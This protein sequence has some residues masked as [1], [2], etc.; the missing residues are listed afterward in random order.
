MQWLYGVGTASVTQNTTAVVGSTGAFE[1]VLPFHEISFAEGAETTDPEIVGNDRYQVVA[2]TDNENITIYP[3]FKPATIAS[4]PF[5][6]YRFSI[7]DQTPAHLA[8]QFAKLHNDLQGMV[9]FSG[10]DRRL[11]LS[12]AAS[13]DEAEVI[14]QSAA[15]DVYRHGLLETNEWRLQRWNSGW[16]T[17]IGTVSG[18][19]GIGTVAAT[20][21][22]DV[23]ASAAA[24]AVFDTQ[25][26][27]ANRGGSI[28][29][30]GF[31][32]HATPERTTWAS[33]QGLGSDG[34][35]GSEDGDMVGKTMRAGTLTEA[36]RAKNTG[37]F[38]AGG[39]EPT[40]T[41][42]PA[43][44][45]YLPGSNTVGLSSASLL[46]VRM[47]AASTVGRASAFTWEYKLQPGA[48]ARHGISFIGYDVT[49]IFSALDFADSAGVASGAINVDQA[50]H[51]TA[52]TTS[53]D[54]R[55]KPNRERL[56]VERA[57]D[58]V[59]AL[60]IWDFDKDG[61]YIRGVGPI[62][63]EAYEVLPRMVQKGDDNESLRP[64]D[65]DYRGWSA[66]KSY[67]VPYLIVAVQHLLE[68][69]EA[70]NPSLGVK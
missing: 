3:A 35:Q 1:D 51:T 22:L 8:A 10:N 49:G 63:Q 15:A 55:G 11:S 14:Y 54:I 43:N 17:V 58:V 31:D 20:Q 5:I 46:L 23:N 12:K 32:A 36:W 65:P 52:Y 18:N 57:V 68:Q 41:V 13:T 39:F 66:E 56:S 69:V 29:F 38:T 70:L 27:A 33:I 60:R 19:V 50:A 53:S 6:V 67:P 61:N 48:T 24:I 62:A 42:M 2:K 28:L 40:G 45:I 34:T 30:Q 26:Y 21:K 64:R 25:A 7:N 9:T 37:L 16:E 59:R 44:G 47:S 4:K